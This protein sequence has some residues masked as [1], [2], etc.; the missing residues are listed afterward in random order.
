M[1]AFKIDIQDN[2]CT[3]EIRKTIFEFNYTSIQNL[4]N[5]LDAWGDI[6]EALKSRIIMHVKKVYT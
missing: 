4:L 1:K 3:I 2:V 6:S 5:Q